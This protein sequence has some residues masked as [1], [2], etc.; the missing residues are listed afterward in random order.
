MTPEQWK[1]V[2]DTVP[3]ASALARRLKGKESTDDYLWD[4]VM[5]VVCKCA[6]V[7]CDDGRSKFTT[8]TTVAVLREAR[9]NMARKRKKHMARIDDCDEPAVR[10]GHQVDLSEVERLQFAMSKL[11][12]VERLVIV[13]TRQVGMAQKDVGA[14]LGCSKTTVGRVARDAEETLIAEMSNGRPAS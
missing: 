10:T 2:T 13:L 11:S 3:L 4:V 12:E 1:L 5:P 9:K 7:W 14:L 8:Y 6:R